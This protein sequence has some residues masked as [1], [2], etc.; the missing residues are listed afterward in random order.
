VVPKKYWDLYP[1]E[2]ITLPAYQKDPEGA[3]RYAAQPSWELR[4]GYI[5]F[6]KDYSVPIPEEKQKKL[7][8]GYYASVSFIDQQIGK[9]INELDRLGLRENTVIVLWG[10]HGWHLGDH[11]MYCKHTNYE[12]STRS[13]LIFSAGKNRI[14]KSNSPTEFVDVYPTLLELSGITSPENL[15]GVSLV[16]LMEKKVEKVKDFAVSQFPREDD[17]MGYTFRNNTHRYTI[18]MKDNF[19]S[20]QSFDESLVDAEELYDYD[21]DPQETKNLINEEDYKAIKEDLK[22]K[23]I[24]FFKTQEVN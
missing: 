2:N 20:D 9:V 24:A 19:R 3:P 17:K 1:I 18:W 16:P 15:D 10:D 4:G 11:N 14:G 13:P 8:Q 23:A 22:S 12:Q 7:I 5:D 21:K 6:P